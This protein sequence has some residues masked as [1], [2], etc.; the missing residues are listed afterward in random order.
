[1]FDE[2]VEPTACCNEQPGP[3]DPNPG[4]YVAGMP[5]PGGGDTGAVLISPFITPGGV[6]V[7]EYNHYSMLRS[8]EDMFGLSHL[9]YAAQDGLQPFGA[10]VF[11]A[12]P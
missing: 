11:T 3:A 1:M 2:A 5:G 12:S 9:G 7:N 6:N 4:G 8:L 10:D